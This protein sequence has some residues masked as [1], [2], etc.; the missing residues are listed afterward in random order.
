MFICSYKILIDTYHA[1]CYARDTNMNDTVSPLQALTIKLEKKG[2]IKKSQHQERDTDIIECCMVE[3]DS[4]CWGLL[5]W[6]HRR[7]AIGAGS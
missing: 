2:E 3:A 5:G 1:R 6:L 7:G 4:S